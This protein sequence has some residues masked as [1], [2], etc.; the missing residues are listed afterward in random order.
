VQAKLAAMSIRDMLSLSE[1]QL[2]HRTVDCGATQDDISRL[3]LAVSN[4]RHC[5]GWSHGKTF[6]WL[7]SALT[8]ITSVPLLVVPIQWLLNVLMNYLLCVI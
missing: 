8:N 4:L 6:D 1:S 2:E 3:V 7:F 5:I